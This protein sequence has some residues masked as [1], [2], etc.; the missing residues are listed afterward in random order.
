MSSEARHG[1]PRKH[2]D[3]FVKDEDYMV[4]FYFDFFRTECCL[5]VIC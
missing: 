3:R 5:V 2:L 4:H 1:F